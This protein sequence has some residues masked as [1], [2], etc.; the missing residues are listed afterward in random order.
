MSK[1]ATAS[2]DI[3]LS[4][5]WAPD[6]SDPNNHHHV[7]ILNRQLKELGYQTWFDDELIMDAFDELISRD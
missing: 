1:E 6:V 3:H 7:P 2:T 5:D 4:C